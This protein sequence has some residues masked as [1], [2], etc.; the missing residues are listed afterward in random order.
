MTPKRLLLI[1]F[2][3]VMLVSACSLARAIQTP[4]PVQPTL[5]PPQN[6]SDYFPLKK[7]AYWVYQGTVKWTKPNS[8]EVAEQEIT[9]KMGVEQV[10]QRNDIV[11]YEML[12][13]PWDLAW[14]DPAKEQSKYGIVQ[15]GGKFY[16]VPLETVARLSNEQDNLSDLVNEGSI[17]LDT[18]LES[19]KKFCDPASLTRSDN[20]YCW[21]VGEAIP[22]DASHISGVDPSKGLLEYPILNQT[23]PDISTMCFVPGVGISRYSYHHNG[24]VSDVDVH[25]IEYFP[26]E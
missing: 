6:S 19:G 8:S 14:Y 26:G 25:L 12:G 22:F 10:I 1:S 13:A 16:K 23:M 11:G 18:P 2:I 5:S 4:A 7:G 21:I 15:V 3:V 24:T 20:M 9:W 17:F